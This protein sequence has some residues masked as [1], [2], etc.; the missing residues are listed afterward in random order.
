M[1][2]DFSFIV[3]SYILMLA[4]GVIFFASVLSLASWG[5]IKYV[6]KIHERQDSH[7]D[8]HLPRTMHPPSV[9]HA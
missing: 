9:G 8:K 7:G 6:K 4:V 1:V 2:I 3:Y 5:L